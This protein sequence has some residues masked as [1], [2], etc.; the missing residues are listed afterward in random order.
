MWG[1]RKDGEYE[2][3][4]F[5][6][7][8]I[9]HVSGALNHWSSQDLVELIESKPLEEKLL[10]FQALLPQKSVDV[11]EYLPLRLQKQLLHVLPSQR[12]ADLLNVLSPDDRTN[13]L[14]ELPTD[15]V[16]QLLKYLNAEERAVS[17]RLL[18]Y[19]ENSIGRL[20]TPDYL[21][22][23]MKWTV[24]EVLDYI[25]QKG[26]D[27]ETVNVVYAVDD[28]GKLLDDFRIRQ[29]LFAS[30]ETKVKELA[31]YKFIALHVE[32]D[33]EMAIELFRKHDRVAL[34]VID[35]KGILLGI[36]TFDD[37]MDV[38]VERDTEDMQKIGG[39]E[40]LSEPYMDTPF[41][42]LMQKRMN[43]LIIL[44]IGEMF[45]ASAMGYF[46]DEIAKAV[47][48]TL[49]IPLIISSGG[50]AGSQASALIIR[51]IALDEVTLRD[52]W[53]VM[54]RE[55]FS[56]LFLGIV[57]GLIGFF[58]VTL[59]GYFSD[60]YG[61][62]WFLLALTVLFSL[63]GVILWGTLMGSMMPLILK[64]L[65]FDPAV[66]S[67]PFVA[68]CVDVTGLIIYFSIAIV[69]LHGTLL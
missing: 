14:E 33:Q 16:N 65:G 32:D 4:T 1:M 47:V 44:F 37:I 40:A 6:P 53:Q 38:A 5:T 63:I 26:K 58:R 61:A 20:M 18:G 48:L 60:V 8:T 25:R 22:I 11:F 59:W 64:R 51:A 27:S 52:W 28:Q 10:I 23:K 29:F 50:N 9:H 54:R 55:I 67:T 69:L 34:P 7:E 13:L 68:T 56:G 12:V 62:H 66:S 57:L 21:A 35:S 42:S 3:H 15:R 17:T 39:V 41:F 36:V 43:W 46:E 45:T 31:D 30:L 24:R 49:F 2:T 19:P